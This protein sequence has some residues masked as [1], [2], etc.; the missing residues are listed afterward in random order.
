M[1]LP[2]TLGISPDFRFLILYHLP[3]SVGYKHTL[4]GA[5]GGGG[6]AG[7]L[8]P[9]DFEEI[10]PPAPTPTATALNAVVAALVMF[11]DTVLV[12]FETLF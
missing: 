10:R 1:R 3:T 11:L 4:G 2:L 8:F 12:T 7:G 6:G 5:G 9:L